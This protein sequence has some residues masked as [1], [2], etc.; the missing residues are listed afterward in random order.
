M[1]DERR[2]HVYVANRIS[3]IKSASEVDQWHYVSGIDNPGDHASRGLYP[4][5]LINSNWFCG[6]EF[7]WN[8]YHC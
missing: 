8:D 7:L 3:Q 1:N 5:D 4:Q 2:F 6:L